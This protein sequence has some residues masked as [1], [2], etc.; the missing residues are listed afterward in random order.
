M[1]QWVFIHLPKTGGTSFQTA[2]RAVVGDDAVSPSF[3]ASSLSEDDAKRLDR[4]R[5]ISGHISLDD[6][7]RYFPGRSILTI[8]RDPV[9]R[10]VSWYY[11]ARSIPAAADLPID[12][13]AAQHNAIDAFFAQDLPALYRNI[14]NRQVRQLG[15]HVLNAAADHRTVIERAK[16]TLIS[17]AWVGRQRSLDLDIDRLANQFPEWKGL[18]LATLN[19]TRY[20]TSRAPL[21][22]DVLRKIQSLNRYDMELVEFA[23]R[24]L[25]N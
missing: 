16:Q 1:R 4:Y 15:D 2:M 12:V 20:P 7:K 22:A 3:V 14:F 10:C 5:V 13:V 8:L 18:A 23:E 17:A 9:E 24:T 11:F 25:F 19:K 6:V 21:G